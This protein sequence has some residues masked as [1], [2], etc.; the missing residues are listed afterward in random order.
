VRARV[1]IYIYIYSNCGTIRTVVISKSLKDHC[2]V[3][4]GS[5]DRDDWHFI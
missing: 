1:Y 3:K 5:M 4:T 2:N